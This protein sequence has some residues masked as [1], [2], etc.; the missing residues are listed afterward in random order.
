MKNHQIVALLGLL[1]VATASAQEIAV[2][3]LEA[4]RYE[5]TLSAEAP[6]AEPVAQALL[7]PTAAKTCNGADP[8]YGK[9]RF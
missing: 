6:V 4:D 1:S 8:L 5:L 3:Q 9:Y 2:G 7:W